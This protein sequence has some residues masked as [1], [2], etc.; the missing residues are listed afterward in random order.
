MVALLGFSMAS[1]TTALISRT[2]VIAPG[3]TEIA[4]ATGSA[5]FNVGIAGGALLGG[6]L[7]SSRGIG[8]LTLVGG[9]LTLLALAVLLSEPL[10]APRKTDLDNRTPVASAEV[11]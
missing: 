10:V 3:S 8:S 2:L 6:V 5:L 1:N 4:S 7:L 11:A 9:A